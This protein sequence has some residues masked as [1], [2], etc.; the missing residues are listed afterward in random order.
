VAALGDAPAAR[1]VV[2]GEDGLPVVVGVSCATGD[3]VDELKAA[4]ARWV[5]EPEAEP[6]AEEELADYLVYRPGRRGGATVRVLRGDDGVRL[7]GAA[8]EDE[9]ARLDEAAA[10]RLLADYVEER[11]LTPLLVRAGAKKG[12]VV[13]VGDREVAY[14][15]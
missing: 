7:V 2:R 9:L 11:R 1:D 6:E 14:R 3:G 10:A 8:I 15:A 4:L 13:K 12:I 5:P